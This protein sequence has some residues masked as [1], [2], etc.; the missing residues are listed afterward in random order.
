MLVTASSSRPDPAVGCG[1]RA[2][3][4]VV[5]TKATTVKA[6][7]YDPKYQRKSQAERVA[8]LRS[9][10]AG[11][12]IIKVRGSEIHLKSEFNILVR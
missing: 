2:I 12:S 9:L 3:R 5:S 11:T 7:G 1:F 10:L 6:P 4:R 8:H